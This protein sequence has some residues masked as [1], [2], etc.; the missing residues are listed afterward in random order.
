MPFILPGSGRNKKLTGTS[1]DI[2]MADINNNGLLDIL[3]CDLGSNRNI[4]RINEGEYDYKQVNLPGKRVIK[5]LEVKNLNED[6]LLDFTSCGITGSK[7]L[8]IRGDRYAD[9]Y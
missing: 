5:S 2:L 8:I 4:W 9:V 7:I 6:G 3:L 1:T